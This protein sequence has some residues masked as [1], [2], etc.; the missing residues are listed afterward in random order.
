MTIKTVTY[1]S[2]LYILYLR[3]AHVQASHVEVG[4]VGY[5]IKGPA[6]ENDFLASPIQS[7]KQITLPC[8]K[9]HQQMR[10]GIDDDKQPRDR[11]GYWR[12]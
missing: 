3:A 7:R 9:R 5:D 6:A 1:R 8:S 2:A 10:Q 12:H 11:T 4:T